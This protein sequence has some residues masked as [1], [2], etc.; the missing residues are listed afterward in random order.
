MHG[1]NYN[2]LGRSSPNAA[3]DRAG[4]RRN[5]ECADGDRDKPRWHR[6]DRQDRNQR[7]LSCN[8]AAQQGPAQ[9]QIGVRVAPNVHCRSNVNCSEEKEQ[10]DEA[11][12]AM[13]C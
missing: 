10:A 9:D 12:L 3:R 8:Q 2:R 5:G 4:R 11:K 6:N 1:R 7:E 13:K